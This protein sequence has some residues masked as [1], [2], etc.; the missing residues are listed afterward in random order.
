MRQLRYLVRYLA[1]A[2]PLLVGSFAARPAAGQVAD[3]VFDQPLDGATWHRGDVL[4]TR[5]SLAV[6]VPEAGSRPVAELVIGENRRE[7]EGRF[8]REGIRAGFYYV[9]Q[10][11]DAAAA[12]EVRMVRVSLGGL[13]VDLSGFSP[14]TYTVDGASPGVP[15]AIDAIGLSS[16]F[17]PAPA[18]GVYRPGDD[19]HWF[20]RF[21]KS[22]AVNGAPVLVQQIGEATREA[23]YRPDLESPDLAGAIFFTYTVQ[24]G[25]CDVDGVG[26]P[27]NA[28]RNGRII[29]ADGYRTADTTHDARDPARDLRTGG[30]R[31][32]ACSVVPVLPASG[33]AL[34]ASVLAAISTHLARKRSSNSPES[35]KGE[36][37]S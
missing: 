14:T 13:N 6:A 30:T 32:V 35:P 34:L 21:H 19:I 23:R 16:F 8:Y 2:F 10:R 18:D 17:F 1:L 33:A 7:V 5:V 25:D 26:I 9:V 22:V 15:P 27:A 12:D 37:R 36:N 11:D 24:P 29:E 31:Q 20:A 28:I 4:R 3:L